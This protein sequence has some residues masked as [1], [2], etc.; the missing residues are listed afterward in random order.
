MNETTAVI[1]GI[2][3]S[4]AMLDVAVRPGGRLGQFPNDEA[5]IDALVARLKALV[6]RLIVLEATGGLEMAS[7]SALAAAG[8]PVAVVNPRQVRDFAK[9]TGQLA[10]TDALDTDILAHFGE[11]IRPAVRPVKDEEIQALTALVTRHRQLL[12]MLTAEKNRLPMASAGTRKD[13]KK[14]IAWLEKRLK[15]IDNQTAQCIKDSPLWLAKDRL[16]RGVPG[17]GPVTSS[18]LLAELPEL[19]RLNRREIAS[20]VGLAPFNRDSGTLQGKRT[21]W[22]GRAQVRSALYMATL[23]AVRCYAGLRGFYER[24][25]RSGKPAKVALTACARKLLTV[26]NAMLKTNTAWTQNTVKTA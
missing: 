4:K 11:V 14:H 8:L 25:R 22:G 19:G 3:V 5:G 26:L 20:L 6:P 15:D 1:V 2:D 17:I 10:K 9:A 24:L 21:V 7:A 13:I 12:G 16:L 18:L 23:S